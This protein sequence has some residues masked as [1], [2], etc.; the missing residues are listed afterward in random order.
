MNQNSNKVVKEA[1]TSQLVEY[2]IRLLKEMPDLFPFLHEFPNPKL[3]FHNGNCLKVLYHNVYGLLDSLGNIR[4]DPAVQAADILFFTQCHTKPHEM[5]ELTINGFT[6]LHLT[7]SKNYFANNGLAC[8][9]KNELKNQVIINHNA[10]SKFFCK[11]DKHLEACLVTLIINGEYV[12]IASV[13]SN[14]GQKHD[15]SIGQLKDFLRKNVGNFEDVNCSSNLFILCDLN[16]DWYK[17]WELRES[18]L[19]EFD[20]NFI[21]PK[22]FTTDD[23]FTLDLGFS[24][25]TAKGLPHELIIYESHY[26]THKPLW[27]YI[28]K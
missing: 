5:D 1:E 16:I 6:L 14:L 24:N 9:V 4:I 26:S 23:D 28:K 12:H 18:F 15:E 3:K 19:G 8:Y 11:K 25:A 22:G 13:F 20:L 27:L 17:D 10:D 7:G 21:N 2:G